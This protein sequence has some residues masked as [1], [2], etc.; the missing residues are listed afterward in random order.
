MEDT[1][2]ISISQAENWTDATAAP[3]SIVHR[4]LWL[5]WQVEWVAKVD[6]RKG[7]RI[8]PIEYYATPTPNSSVEL[9]CTSTTLCHGCIRGGNDTSCCQFLRDYR[10]REQ[11]HRLERILQRAKRNPIFSLIFT[12]IFY[13]QEIFL[14]YVLAYFTGHARSKNFFNSTF[15]LKFLCFPRW[16]EKINLQTGCHQLSL[17]TSK[18]QLKK[19][20]DKGENC[21]SDFC[22]SYFPGKLLSN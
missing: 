6:R 14:Q 19:R 17:G 16:N 1:D 11:E 15:F 5:W 13:Y 22:R 7:E 10:F 3:T 2:S 4:R 12:G 20:A 8:P 21:G 9:N 18:K